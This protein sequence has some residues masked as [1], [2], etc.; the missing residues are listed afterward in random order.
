MYLATSNLFALFLYSLHAVTVLANLDCS[1]DT[2][3]SILPKNTTVTLAAPITR[4]GAF[5]Q[6]GVNISIS[7]S[8]TKEALPICVV[9][10][11]VQSSSN[12]SFNTGVLLPNGWNGRLMATGNPGFGGGLRWSFQASVLKYG[13]AVTISTDTGHVGAPNNISFA[14]DNPDGIIDWSYRSLHE[15]T[16]LAKQ[17]AKA[18]YGSDV[19]HSY[20]TACSNGGRQGLKEVQMFPN[21]YDG[22][23]AGAPP[24]QITHLH[25]WA[26]QLGLWNLPANQSRHIPAW[27]FSIISD[28]IMG[29]CDA[30]DGLADQIIQDP[31]SCNF[32]SNMIMVCIISSFYFSY[33]GDIREYSSIS[34]ALKC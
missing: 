15:S 19:E 20:Y 16:V 3:A 26:V 10:L 1:P 5:S 13:A 2:F 14:I 17:L 34:G 11:N 31:Y 24:W 30:Q 9:Q 32:S 25:P 8:V 23:L 27:K 12:T 29:Q 7:E 28:L 18:F 33:F 21:D 22:V 4:F 6:N